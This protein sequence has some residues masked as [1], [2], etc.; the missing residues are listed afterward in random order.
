MRGS[1]MPEP[2]AMPPTAKRPPVG[3]LHGHGFAFRERVGRHDGAHGGVAAVVT[4]R[5]G[6]PP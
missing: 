5:R 4:E 2:L 3:G 1:I 6:A